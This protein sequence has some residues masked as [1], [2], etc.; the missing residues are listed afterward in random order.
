MSSLRSREWAGIALALITAVAFALSNAAASLAYHGGSNPLTVAA[1]RFVLPTLA[2]VIWLSLRG[3]PLTLPARDGWIAAILGAVTAIYTWALLSAI[4]AIPLALA[5]LVF[6]LFPL[7][8]TVVLG[9]C[10]WEKLGWPIVAAIVVAF[11]GLALALDPQGGRFSIEGVTLAVVAAIGLGIVIAVS[12]RVIRAG[13]SRP[14]TLYMATVAGALLIAFCAARN[15]FAFPR[16]GLGWAGF[17]ATSVLYAFAM[18]AFF[19]AISMIGAV[20]ASLL[21]YAEP[22]V[23][24]IVGVAMLNEA[25]APIQVAGIALVI[26][27]LVGA[28]VWQPRGH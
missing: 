2:L 17:L 15:G 24:A 18:I 10:G 1:F 25:L 14:V 13:D 11:V 26:V 16:T 22:V 5:I 9:L 4:G 20:R 8:A 23:S 28:T 3:A 7:V 21:S 19:I 12:S 6:Y 27:A